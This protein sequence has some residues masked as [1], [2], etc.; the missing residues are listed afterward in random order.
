LFRRHQY[1]LRF[2]KWGLPNIEAFGAL[3]DG[4]RGDSRLAQNASSDR[5]SSSMSGPGP[6]IH[7]VP[8]S[9]SISEE[10][11]LGSFTVGYGAHAS[12]P[13]SEC[14]SPKNEFFHSLAN[15]A[16]SENEFQSARSL[17]LDAT[18]EA[19]AVNVEEAPVTS[20]ETLLSVHTSDTERILP[21]SNEIQ[22]PPGSG[23][24]MVD[25]KL[26]TVYLRTQMFRSGWFEYP[27][28]VVRVIETADVLL[29]VGLYEQAYDFYRKWWKAVWSQ[30][31]PAYG[32]LSFLVSTL[33][34]MSR[35]ASTSTECAEMQANMKQ[36]IHFHQMRGVSDPGE[37][38]ILHTHLAILLFRSHQLTEA[39]HHCERV[40]EIMKRVKRKD[41][42]VVG[43]WRI[44]GNLLYEC[45]IQGSNDFHQL[46]SRK[47]W[48]WFERERERF[49]SWTAE[50][51]HD[52]TMRS[53]FTWCASK[54][55]L[56]DL[57]ASFLRVIHATT[58]S[59]WGFQTTTRALS[60]VL[61][62]HLWGTFTHESKSVQ[63]LGAYIVQWV[64]EI[65]RN[66][67]I[68]CADLF[69]AIALALANLV[70]P[71]QV[72]CVVKGLEGMKPSQWSAEN[73]FE[74][75][76]DVHE[77]ALLLVSEDTTYKPLTKSF[78]AAHA[79]INLTRVPKQAA[80]PDSM[81]FSIE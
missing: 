16:S 10:E 81:S 12:C 78:L 46:L 76:K 32:T 45:I 40:V 28:E 71:M 2:Q 20:M 74:L 51:Q 73:T 63:A 72:A 53:L 21:V 64:H 70:S 69:D 41:G 3:Q 19:A 30:S 36:V 17:A 14:V 60:I 24:M 9:D 31:A 48:K 23:S 43:D 4:S 18:F 59:D 47:R 7:I 29:A 66:M 80:P 1:K 22:V 65:T 27:A 37:E 77:A 62:R 44:V 75:L 61:F 50:L 55:L 26:P 35:A 34:N 67:H 57:R 25:S 8:V 15:R 49:E 56:P 79:T 54:L 33:S 6:P 42:P 13:R 39:L 68:N 38:I 5:H 52:E 58:N 11:L